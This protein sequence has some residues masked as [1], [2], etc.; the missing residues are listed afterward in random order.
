MNLAGVLCRVTMMRAFI[1]VTGAAVGVIDGE[2]DTVGDIDVVGG[3]DVLGGEV[4]NCVVLDDGFK[5]GAVLIIVSS[6]PSTTL[7]STC[8]SSSLIVGFNV[9]RTVGFIVGISPQGNSST[10]P[11]KLNGLQGN[12]SYVTTPKNVRGE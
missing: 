2:I 3:S 5:V 6:S 12:L 10:G 7:S 9:G 8:S 4:A 1:D 11:Y